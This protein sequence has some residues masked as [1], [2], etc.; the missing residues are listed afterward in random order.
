MKFNTNPPAGGEK[1]IYDFW[2]KENLFRATPTSFKKAYSLLI[3]PPNLT[4]ELHLGHAMQHSILDAISRFKR[5]QGYDVLLLPG[6]DHAGILFEATFDRE[7]AKKNLSKEKL[8]RDEWLKRAWKFKEEVY[9]S[10]S[11]SWKI[12][13][14][15]ADWSR[16]I[17]TLD[18]GPQKAVFNE[19]KTYYERGLIYK[20]PYIVQWCP[21]CNTAIEDVELEYKERKEEL[22]FV[23]YKIQGTK[24][25]YIEVATTRPETIFADSGIAIYP[26]H[27]KFKKYIGKKA[28]IPLSP[29]ISDFVPIFEDSRVEKKFGTG[30][31]KVTPG[32]DILDY[33]IGKDHDLKIRQVVDKKGRM[34]ELAG[35][36]LKSLKV[37]RAREKVIEILKNNNAL[38]SVK[39]Y[40]HSVAIC[41]RC[42][43]VVE[44]LISEEWF[45]K[46]DAL[47]K[48]AIK[49]INA[50]KIKF[51][52][53]N[54]AKILV[55]WLSDIHD[56]CISRSLW[57]GHRIP[58]WYP[59]A[60]SARSGQVADIQVSLES[61]GPG[62][63]QDEQVLD[64][65]FSSGIWP[66]STLGWPD[67]KTKNLM[68]KKYFPWDFEITAPE[69]KYLWIARMI[70]ISVYFIG[71][72]PFK[73]MFFHGMLRDLQGRKF[74]KSLGNGIEPTYLIDKW[75]VD[76]TRM[77]LYTYSI[78]GRDGRVSREIL[79]ERGK[80]FRNF[81]TKLQNI[82]KFVLDLAPEPVH[83]AGVSTT[84]LSPKHKDDK[85][86]FDELN[87]TI[88]NVTHHLKKIELH[89]ATEE[90]YEFVWHKFADIYIESTKLRRADAQ[91]TLEKVLK[92]VLIILHPFMPFVTEEIYQKFAEKKKS[93]MLED[94]PL[95]KSK[96]KSQK[97]KGF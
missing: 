51:L 45:V 94:W 21:K 20:G 84:H 71:D 36:K 44:P 67:A 47:A 4:G 5:M 57:W 50:G 75:S 8:G 93:I 66:L 83:F 33:Q 52:P 19:F 89:L 40:K 64:T 25:E 68:L 49:A 42:K 29:I 14:L 95:I 38:A 17:F 39:P 27:P 9:N 81:A 72:I 73:E 77:A 30:A 86:I 34:T 82:S 48:G 87:Q 43:S 58:V 97:S 1:E 69:I 79:D 16:E 2:Q 92:D 18:L 55:D 59:S 6:V 26:N 13:G 32:H 11:A 54:Y 22:Y 41:E 76:A 60:R 62:W 96:G 80:N 37:N 63:I 91:K 31:L 46:V 61:P 12:M 10:V 70:M 56:W 35:E 15:S 90:I 65:W 28:Q 88:K 23:C 24:D 7:L 85:W 53:K 3:P 78:P 74:S